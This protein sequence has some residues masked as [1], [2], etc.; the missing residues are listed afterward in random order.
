MFYVHEFKALY[1][2]NS[3]RARGFTKHARLDATT[4]ARTASRHNHG[5]CVPSAVTIARTA[6]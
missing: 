6:S 2:A 1:T 3:G 5:A 4:I